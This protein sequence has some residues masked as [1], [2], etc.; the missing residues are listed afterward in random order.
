MR[1]REQERDKMPK[2]MR[3]RE[4]GRDNQEQGK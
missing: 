2:T 1:E 3:Y 4:R